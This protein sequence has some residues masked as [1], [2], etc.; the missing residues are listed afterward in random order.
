[1]DPSVVSSSAC[2]AFLLNDLDTCKNLETQRLKK[3][4]FR[5]PVN[6]RWQKDSGGIGS[7]VE[8]CSATQLY[9]GYSI[10]EFTPRRVK[11]RRRGHADRPEI[12]SCC[13]ADGRG[14]VAFSEDAARG[15][16][17]FAPNRSGRT[18]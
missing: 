7:R 13:R 11:L 1:M 15:R 2:K 8:D 9:E 3:K 5:S 18:G 10:A 12:E 6:E 17:N 4:P 16:K 14:T